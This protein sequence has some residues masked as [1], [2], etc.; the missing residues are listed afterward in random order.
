MQE[1]SPKEKGKGAFKAARIYAAKR[2]KKTRHSRK[3]RRGS[4]RIC[5]D[6]LEFRAHDTLVGDELQLALIEKNRMAWTISDGFVVGRRKTS[7]AMCV[8]MERI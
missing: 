5:G 1:P 7:A 6:G 8:M 4:C 2:K 3:E